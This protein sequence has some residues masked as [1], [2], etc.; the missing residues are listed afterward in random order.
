MKLGEYKLSNST[1][2]LPPKPQHPVPVF[3]LPLDPALKK[4]QPYIDV[5]GSQYPSP[6]VHTNLIVWFSIRCLTPRRVPLNECLWKPRDRD[7][8]IDCQL[9]P[10]FLGFD[11]YRR[12]T[13]LGLKGEVVVNKIL[14][15]DTHCG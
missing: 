12:T 2:M 8:F 3:K 1:K 4:H 9:I 7:V 13:Y 6:F 14:Y 11:A 15:F 10:H 5:L